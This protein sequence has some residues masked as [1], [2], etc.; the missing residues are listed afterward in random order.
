MATTFRHPVREDLG[1]ITSIMN[2]SRRETAFH[3]DLTTEEVNTETFEDPDYLTE[4]AWLA[5]DGERTVAYGIAV[6]EESRLEAGLDDGIIELDVLP[7]A[8]GRGIEDELVGLAVEYLRS[9]GVD[10]A[11]AR[12]EET[13][14]W[15]ETLLVRH[16]FVKVRHLFRLAWKGAPEPPVRPMPE[17]TTV[18]HTMFA[19]MSDAEVATLLDVLNDTFSGHFDFAPQPLS[20]WTRWRD[21]SEE[22]QMVSLAWKGEEVV[23]FCVT[24]DSRTYNAE[25]G[26]R[27]GWIELLGVR[28]HF[29]C[30]GL[31]TAMLLDGMG[32]LRSLGHDTVFIGVDAEN[33]GALGLY[34][35][36]GFEVQNQSRAYHLTLRDPERP[37][38]LG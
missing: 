38:K 2:G 37:R 25:R 22:P 5:S 1:L 11:S 28:K 33:E 8:R 15:K 31:G 35:S 27:S 24:E 30:K 4:G 17:G 14:A 26:L 23:A 3:R 34:R 12:V 13:E 36:L 19:D 9:R 21:A 7:D 32:W 6:V 18:T 16:D 20:R 29:R 10:H